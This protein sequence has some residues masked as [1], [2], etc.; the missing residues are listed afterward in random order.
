MDARLLASVKVTGSAS[1]HDRRSGERKVCRVSA[2]FCIPGRA[3]MRAKTL[4]LSTKGL[5]LLLPTALG[6]GTV[7]EVSFGLYVDGSLQEISAKIEVSNCVFLSSDVRIG[8]RFL[9]IGEASK[10]AV[11]NFIR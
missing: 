10:K 4:D 6:P 2:V 8:C 3:P 9:F 11:A 5:A 7:G 1:S